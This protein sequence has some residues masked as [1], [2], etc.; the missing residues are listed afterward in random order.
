MKLRALE[1]LACPVCNSNFE[2]R[3][4]AKSGEEIVSGAL[5]CSQGHAFE[6]KDGL[7]RLRLD[8]KLDQAPVQVQGDPLSVAASFGAE[9]SHFDY[10]KDRTW[11]Q[12]VEER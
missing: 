1:W 10:D 2:L 8:Q 12:S 7:P 6:I 11:H 9:W 3:N 5:V 4:P